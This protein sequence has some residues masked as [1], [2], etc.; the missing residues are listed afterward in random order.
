MNAYNIYDID[1]GPN[2]LLNNFVLKNCLFGA[3][4]IVQNSDKSMCIVA[5]E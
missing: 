2:N 5:M 1:N 4:N 3:T